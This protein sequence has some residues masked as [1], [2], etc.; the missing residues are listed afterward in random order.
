MKPFME[1][2]NALSSVGVFW[3]SE[4]RGVSWKAIVCNSV[5]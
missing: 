3:L 2:S 1:H 4:Q 5:F